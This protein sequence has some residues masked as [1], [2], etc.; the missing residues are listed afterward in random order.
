MWVATFSSIEHSGLGRY[1]DRLNPDGDRDAV[2]QAW[3]MLQPGGWLAIGVP[4]SCTE[5]GYIEFN[6]H[7]VYGYERLA[8]ISQGFELFGFVRPCQ[9]HEREPHWWPQPVYV[10]RKPLAGVVV[11]PLT[12]AD[13]VTARILSHADHSDL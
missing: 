12:A 8:H 7:R 11:P 10:L 4:M 6:A 5:R 1:G 3:C 13:F 2:R 9:P